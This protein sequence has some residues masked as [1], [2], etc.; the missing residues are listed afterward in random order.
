MGVESVRLSGYTGKI[1]IT[2]IS[3]VSLFNFF[4][5]VERFLQRTT[6]ATSNERIFQPV[7]SDF[8]QPATS[9]RRK[10][11]ILQRVTN[12]FLQRDTSTTSN[13]QILERVTSDYTTS[14][15][16]RVKSYASFSSTIYFLWEI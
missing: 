12:N 10:E 13:E 5:G 4:V 11:R 8:L 3:I 14:N 16:Q 6:S 7:T 9:A 1:Y 15:E 2:E